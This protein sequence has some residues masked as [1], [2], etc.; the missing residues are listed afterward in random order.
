MTPTKFDALARRYFGELLE[1][2]GFSCIGSE[3]TT[4]YRHVSPDIVHFV[5]IDLSS[6]GSWYD[7]KVFASSPKIEPE[8]KDRFPDSVGVPSG[9]LCYLHPSSGV[10]PDQKRYSCKTE[11][12]FVRVFNSEVAPALDAKGIPYLDRI[13][14]IDSL[15]PFIHHD[16][17]LGVALWHAGD[18]E[19]AKQVLAKEAR[20]LEQIRDPTGRVGAL[21]RHLNSLSQSEA[22]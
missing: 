18:K 20:R 3:A 1:P 11:Q 13:I 8:F 19:Q 9:S 10:G 21:L 12:D 7:V 4:F 16:F 17:Y 6:G 22:T 15:L 2:K 14:S 5:L